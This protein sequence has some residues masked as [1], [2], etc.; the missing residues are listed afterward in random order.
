MLPL[1]TLVWLIYCLGNNHKKKWKRNVLGKCFR[2]WSKWWKQIEQREFV[3]QIASTFLYTINNISSLSI[4]SILRPQIPFLQCENNLCISL[5]HYAGSKFTF[6]QSTVIP[7]MKLLLW[8]SLKQQKL[9]HG[10]GWK[11]FVEIRGYKIN[12]CDILN[13]YFMPASLLSASHVLTYSI[14]PINLGRRNTYHLCFIDK[15]IDTQW[16]PQRS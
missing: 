13:T 7:W 12:S 4:K 14:F 10:P 9:V 2:E 8:L 3:N 6:T 1:E 15:S 16:G 5:Y 11:F